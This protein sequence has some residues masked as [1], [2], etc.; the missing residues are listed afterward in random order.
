MEIVELINGKRSVTRWVDEAGTYGSLP[1]TGLIP[2]K[3]AVVSPNAVQVWEPVLGSADGTITKTYI[4]GVKD[5]KFNIDYNPQTWRLLVMA[6]GYTD[7]VDET[8][9]YSH[10]YA[11]KTNLNLESFSLQVIDNHTTDIVTTYTGCKFNSFDISW[12]SAGGGTGKFIKCV[13][14]V[15]C[16]DV[17]YTETEKTV[18]ASPTTLALLQSR[19]VVLTVNNDAT[20]YVRCLS[21]NIRFD[22]DLDDG[23]YSNAAVSTARTENDRQ[24]LTISGKFVLRY[25]DKTDMTLFAAGAAISNT[26]VEF[27]R[28]VTTDTAIFAFGNFRIVKASSPTKLGGFNEMTIEYLAD[29]CLPEITDDRDDYYSTS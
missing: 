17:S 2:L 22:N 11:L 28:T 25:T 19:Q 12:N 6:I 4:A 1:A 23:W 8:G 3:N 24:S 15:L 13:G 29:T 9:H 20:K 18:E 16:R 7:N 14:E 10:T 26:Q 27:R 21:G 5:I